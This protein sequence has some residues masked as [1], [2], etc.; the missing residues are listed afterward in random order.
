MKKIIEILTQ[1]TNIINS[2]KIIKICGIIEEDEIYEFNIIKNKKNIILH[3][4]NKNIVAHTI[5]EIIEKLEKEDNNAN[6]KK[7]F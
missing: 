2:N 6:A 7:N 5:K 4:K 3:Y 1:A